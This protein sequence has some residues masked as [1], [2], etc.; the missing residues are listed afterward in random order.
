M[1]YIDGTN[2]KARIPEIG[3]K[4]VWELDKPHATEL[5][6]VVKVYWNGEEWWVRTRRYP[7]V[8][9]PELAKTYPNTLSRFSEAVTAVGSARGR[10]VY[11]SEGRALQFPEEAK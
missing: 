5:I 4:W 10:W 11:W 7:D 3:S 8:V 9:P 2:V 1:K 6:E